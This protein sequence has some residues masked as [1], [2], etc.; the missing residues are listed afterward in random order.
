MEPGPNIETF[1]EVT[2]ANGRNRL[3]LRFV[4]GPNPELRPGLKGYNFHSIVWE[5]R[6][7]DT[8]KERVVITQEDFQRGAAQRWVNE[9]HSL[10]PSI[11]SAI[12]KV[13]EGQPPDERGGVSF[14]Y[15]WREWD[16]LRNQQ[17]RVLRDCDYP[18]APLQGKP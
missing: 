9:L 10:D 4:E 13:A 11:G 2:D 5:V 17:I 8:W 12:I 6:D 1:G 16:L 18:F 14:E 7:G 3:L 15:F